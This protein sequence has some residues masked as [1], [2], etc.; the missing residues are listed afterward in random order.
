MQAVSLRIH[1]GGLDGEIRFEDGLA[2]VIFSGSID[3]F[4]IEVFRSVLAS[5]E[6]LKPHALILSFEKVVHLSARAIGM[7]SEFAARVGGRTCPVVIVCSERHV[8]RRIVQLL[9]YPHL[10]AADVE[11]ALGLLGTMN[12]GLVRSHGPGQNSPST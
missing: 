10:L 6:V 2:S 7:L 4:N 11:E 5:A 1:E 12:A 8:V 3:P 9:G